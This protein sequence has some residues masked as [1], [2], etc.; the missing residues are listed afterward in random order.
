MI[1]DFH[2]DLITC[3]NLTLQQKLQY[4]NEANKI[5]TKM[6]LALYIATPITLQQ[7]FELLKPFQNTILNNA[8]YKHSPNEMPNIFSIENVLF[9]ES[10]KESEI[11]RLPFAI[12]GITWNYQ[13]KYASGCLSMGGLS[14]TGKILIDKLQEQNKII[15]L[16]HTNKE[17]FFDIIDY[18]QTKSYKK[19]V[20]THTCF[21]D[22]FNHPRNI[23]SEQIKTIIDCNGI[24]G[25]TLVKDFLGGDTIDTIVKHIDYFCNKFDYKHLAIGTDY[26]G[27]KHLDCIDNYKKFENLSRA[28]SKFGYSNDVIKMIFY[29]NLNNYIK[30]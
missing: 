28:L 9:D 10:V 6:I 5:D 24:I 26:F 12:Y 15:D 4:I 29:D 25:L 19:V 1:Y 11:A 8:N 2:T 21:K 7:I 27:T 22:I 17:S 3:N 20:C 30:S 23:D 16:A 13:N 18:T 14:Q